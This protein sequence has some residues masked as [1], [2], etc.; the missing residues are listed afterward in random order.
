MKRRGK[1]YRGSVW[2]VYLCVALMVGTGFVWLLL[3]TF[4]QREGDF[5]PE[6]HPAQFYLI[7]FH[8]ALAM[9]MMVIFGGLLATHVRHYWRKRE[10]RA[11]GVILIATWTLL[12]VSAY[13]LYYAGGEVL[14]VVAHWMHIALGLGLPLWL[15]VHVWQRQKR[16]HKSLT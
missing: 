2:T 7:R 9:G 11:T 3:D 15:I 14:R 10:K 13:T 12:M 4:S 5:G 6:K 8:G 1:L 16:A